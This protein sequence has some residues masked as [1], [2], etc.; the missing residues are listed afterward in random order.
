MKILHIIYFSLLHSHLQDC[1]IDWGQAYKTAIQPIQV[2]QNRI[3]TYMTF[4]NQRSTSANNIFKLLK[5]LQMSDLYQ[6]IWQS[7]CTSP[8]IIIWKVFFRTVQ[9]TW[10]GHKATNIRKCSVLELIMAKMLQYAGPV[11]WDCIS[12]RLKLCHYMFSYQVK[13]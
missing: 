3:L 12:N 11:A 9:H 5:S 7:L 10:S 1:R 2:L 4:T 6:F 8:A 13:S